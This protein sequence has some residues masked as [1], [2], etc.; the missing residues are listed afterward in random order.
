MNAPENKSQGHGVSINFDGQIAMVNLD[1]RNNG[2]CPVD[3]C[4]R[5]YVRGRSTTSALAA[6]A[7]R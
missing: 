3:L 2:G 5:L 7:D 6:L 4:D 1:L